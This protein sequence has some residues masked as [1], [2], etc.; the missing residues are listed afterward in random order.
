MVQ[1]PNDIRQRLWFLHDGAPVHY[2]G[3]ITN[4]LNQSFGQQWI[5]RGGPVSWPA[6]SPD[7]TKM[8]FSIWGF[9]KDQVYQMPPTTRDDMK[10][11]IRDCF[12]SITREMCRN[13][14]RSFE[15]R[16]GLCIQANGGHFEQLIR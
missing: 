10:I 5:G 15:D 13:M 16:V 7:L 2:T 3:P 4:F 11:R 6:R 12:R 14:S 9:V 1:I 8:D